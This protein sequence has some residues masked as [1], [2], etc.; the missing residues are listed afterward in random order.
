MLQIVEKIVVFAVLQ[1]PFLRFDLFE[2][3][4]IGDVEIIDPPHNEY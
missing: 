2:E 3:R 4:N 1:Q